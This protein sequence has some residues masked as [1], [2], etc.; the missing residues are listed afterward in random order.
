MYK[1]HGKVLE[2]HTMKYILW[3][4]EILKFEG[5]DEVDSALIYAI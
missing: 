2:D 3:A 4:T 5:K 1:V